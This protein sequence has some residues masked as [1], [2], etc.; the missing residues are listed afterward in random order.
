MLRGTPGGVELS[1]VTVALA[2]AVRPSAARAVIVKVVV[3]LT[4]TD[5]DPESP[6]SFP[7]IDAETAL[8]VCQFTTAVSLFCSVAVICAVGAG[9]I[10]VTVAL[11]VAVR[12]SAARATSVNVVCSET[13]MLVDP[14]SPTADP[15]IV[16]DAAFAVCQV[17]N[18]VVLFCSVAVICAV[19]AGAMGVTVALAVAVRPSAARA[20]S[21][22][23][24]CPETAMLVD[25]LSPTAVPLIV[26]EVAL[27][28][29]HVTNA[30]VL[31]CSVA[32]ICAV[33]AGAMGVT[34]AF[35]V[36]VRPSVARATSVNVVCPDTVMLSIRSARPWSR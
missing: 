20:T 12:P 24:V 19:G 28:V 3:A 7:L 16:A 15:L 21:V 36:A 25:P 2:V 22:N 11:A 13:A 5:V 6:T 17:T 31:F 34:V 27:L 18:A 23:V 14:L 4:G 8:L 30:V 10:G 33:G 26:A 35:A 29:C 32:V 1:T 9:V